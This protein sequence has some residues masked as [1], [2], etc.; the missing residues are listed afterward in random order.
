MSSASDGVFLCRSEEELGGAIESN[1]GSTSVFHHAKEEVVLQEY[2][3]GAEFV[4]NTVSLNGQ[5]RVLDMWQADK[6][7]DGTQILYGHQTLVT[8]SSQH[9]DV[10]DFALRVLDAVGIAG[11]AAHLEVVRTPQGV[12]LIEVNARPA[13]HTPRATRQRGEDQ[14]SALAGALARPDAFL[15]R[16]RQSP[17]YVLDGNDPELVMVVFLRATQDAEVHRTD[18]LQLSRLPTFRR[19]DRVG[20]AMF[21]DAVEEADADSFWVASKT[22]GLFSVPLT[23]LLAGRR[24]E[25]ETD[26]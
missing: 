13:G 23:L 10:V 22:E 25:L 15:E 24:A 7:V 21:A 11:G 19:F 1:L 4:V 16:A 12:R 20:L 5:H 26:L 8:D 9:A 3:Q 2:L 17:H 18:L 14:V 6:V